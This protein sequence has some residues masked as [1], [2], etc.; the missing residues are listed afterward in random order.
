MKAV[1]NFLKTLHLSCLTGFWILSEAVNVMSFYGEQVWIVFVIDFKQVYLFFFSTSASFQKLSS[2]AQAKY[3]LLNPSHFQIKTSF[4]VDVDGV[5][6][7]RGLLK[8]ILKVKT[9]VVYVPWRK[10]PPSKNNYQ[11]RDR[12]LS[13]ASKSWCT[14]EILE[15]NLLEEMEKLTSLEFNWAIFIF[16]IFI[17]LILLR[18]FKPQIFILFI[19]FIFVIIYS[20]FLNDIWS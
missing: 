6:D 14:G 17:F 11:S 18:I 16:L 19:Y 4:I 9:L 7:W 3:V 15:C 13:R 2:F 10:F 1:S 12:L 20:V 5:Y 8:N